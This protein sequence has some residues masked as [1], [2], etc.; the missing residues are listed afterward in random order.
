MI[1]IKTD[2]YRYIPSKNIN[3]FVDFEIVIAMNVQRSLIA[4]KY[5][6][7]CEKWVLIMMLERE[8]R[9]NIYEAAGVAGF[10]VSKMQQRNTKLENL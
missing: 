1:P 6:V 5:H 8:Q 7:K 4:K 10:M 3:K 9:Q 2:L